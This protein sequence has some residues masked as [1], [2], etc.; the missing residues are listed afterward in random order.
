MTD[1]VIPRHLRLRGSKLAYHLRKC[2][3]EAYRVVRKVRDRYGVSW[4]TAVAVASGS[5]QPPYPYRV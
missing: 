3:P 4:D 2:Y 1:Q 5:L